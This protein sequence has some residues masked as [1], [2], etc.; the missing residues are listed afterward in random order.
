M[1]TLHRNTQNSAHSPQ[2]ALQIAD[3]PCHRVVRLNHIFVFAL[4][5]AFLRLLPAD[6]LLGLVQLTFQRLHPVVH[7]LHLLLVLVGV[8]ALV[9]QLHDQLLDFLVQLAVGLLLR[10]ALF[11]FHLRGAPFKNT[12]N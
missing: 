5:L 1:Y 8:A 11:R 12:L 7:L 4:R 6:L 10:E 3:F 2:L 9:L